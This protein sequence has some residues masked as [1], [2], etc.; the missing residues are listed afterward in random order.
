MSAN[1]L[2]PNERELLEIINSY[3]NK[4]YALLKAI[5]VVSEFIEKDE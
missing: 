2:T 5:E 4:E 1:K 3:P